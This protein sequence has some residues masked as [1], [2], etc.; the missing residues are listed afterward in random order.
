MK[1]Y[2]YRA[3]R[4]TKNNKRF[5]MFFTI[6]MIAIIVLGGWWFWTRRNANSTAEINAPAAD[7]D[8]KEGTPRTVTES[9]AR[10]GGIIDDAD[11][12]NKTKPQTDTSSSI[13]SSSGN[14][15]V[16]QPA[17]NTLLDNDATI[18]GSSKVGTIS[19]RLIDDKIGVIGTGTL[20][21]VSGKFSGTFSFSSNGSEGRVDV[22][23]TLADDTEVDV[24]EI[25]VRFK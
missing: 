11:K 17:K 12:P 14:I 13:S 19:Y 20:K 6:F 22:F 2:N 16:N 23:R 10:D 25:P 7:S 21:V 3:P 8:F 18:S 9:V 5:V 24:V 4:K 1:T 15:T